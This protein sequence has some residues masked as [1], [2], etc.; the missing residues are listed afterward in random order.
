MSEIVWN[1]S[2]NANIQWTQSK[3]LDKANKR[4]PRSSTA[5]IKYLAFKAVISER[6]VDHVKAHHT[7]TAGMR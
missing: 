6:N 2:K 4:I 7:C 5:F 1:Y 3:I